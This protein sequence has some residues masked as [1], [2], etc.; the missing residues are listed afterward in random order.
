MT[1]CKQ[2]NLQAISASQSTSTHPNKPETSEVPRGDTLDNLASALSLICSQDSN[3]F[4]SALYQ[5]IN[6]LAVGVFIVD[7]NGQVT[8][9]NAHTA[10]IVG[11]SKEELLGKQ[12][13]EVLNDCHRDEYKQLF[14]TLKHDASKKLSHG[15]KEVVINRKDG[16]FSYADLSISRLPQTMVN[17][18]S[19]FIG[20]LHDLSSHHAKYM[21]LKRLSRTDHLTGL[22]NR[23]AFDEALNELWIECTSNNQ[24]ISVLFIDIDYFKQFNDSYGHVNGDKCLKKVAKTIAYCVPS[25]DCVTG[26]YGGE[27]FAMILPRCNE[28]IAEVVAK[29]V[30]RSINQLNFIDQGLQA[31]AKVTVSQGI[32]CAEKG[33]FEQVESLLHSADK[34]LYK[35]KSNGRDRIVCSSN[36][37]ISD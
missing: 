19:M 25:R 36:P 28:Q 8:V 16:K 9:A 34:S 29:Q 37:A 27:E 4:L 20:V 33:N 32:A 17:A 6:V 21:K 10:K 24:P 30:R 26:R 14:N 11:S 13:C 18:Q 7:E 1:N 31:H 35:A 15:P 5:I 3:N 12:W 2:C 23:N 22:A